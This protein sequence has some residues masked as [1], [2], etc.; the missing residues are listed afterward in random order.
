MALAGAVVVFNYARSSAAAAHVE[1]AVRDAG[2]RAHA[3]QIDL[4]EPRAVDQLMAAA[5]EHLDGLDILADNAALNSG[6]GRPNRRHR[7]TAVGRHD[8]RQR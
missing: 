6:T 1:G 2:G 5:A 8:D 3:V 7:R 4:A